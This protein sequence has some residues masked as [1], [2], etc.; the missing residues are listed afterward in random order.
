MKLQTKFSLGDQLWTTLVEGGNGK[1][2]SG[3]WTIIAISAYR[4]RK[5]TSTVYELTNSK[6]TI[7]ERYED[8]LFQGAAEG[9]IAPLPEKKSA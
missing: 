6:S 8:E 7:I 2:F 3:P 4:D 9:V 1:V 5:G